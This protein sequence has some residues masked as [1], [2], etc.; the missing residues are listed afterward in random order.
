MAGRR[1]DRWRDVQQLE[2]DIGHYILSDKPLSE[3]EWIMQRTEGRTHMQ[4]LTLSAIAAAVL[5]FAQEVRAQSATNINALQGLA[6][7]S[8]LQNTVAG[9]VALTR[10]LAI[11]GAIQ[12]GAA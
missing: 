10:N 3:D 11:T 7:V 5:L 1:K 2:A 8:A 4:F 6:P 12:N 9:K